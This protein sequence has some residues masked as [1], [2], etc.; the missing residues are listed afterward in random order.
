MHFILLRIID[1]DTQFELGVCW[2]ELDIE[3]G[4]GSL[5]G[6]YAALTYRSVTGFGSNNHH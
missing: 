4:K 2:G 6:S 5:L 3:R 1:N